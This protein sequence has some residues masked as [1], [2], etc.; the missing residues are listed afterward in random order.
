VEDAIRDCDRRGDFGPA[1]IAL[2]Q[3]VY[4]TNDHRAA[5]KRRINVL[6]GSEVVEEKS[7]GTDGST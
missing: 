7:Y 2:A 1:F 3:S 5:L 6:L 4:R